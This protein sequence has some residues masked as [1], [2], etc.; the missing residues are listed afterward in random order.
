M[1]YTKRQLDI[2]HMD[3]VC[4]TI[5]K[6]NHTQLVETYKRLGGTSD[7]MHRWK[8]RRLCLQICMKVGGIKLARRMQYRVSPQPSP[9]DI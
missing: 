5:L 4:T 9:F 1:R 8:K 6:M 3:R 2:A 7:Q